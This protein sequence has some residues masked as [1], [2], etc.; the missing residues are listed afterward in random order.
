MLRTTIFRLGSIKLI[1]N[2]HNLGTW[3][4]NIYASVVMSLLPEERALSTSAGC[5]VLIDTH[6][7]RQTY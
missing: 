7:V 1:I 5:Q 6:T 4:V 2:H 3:P